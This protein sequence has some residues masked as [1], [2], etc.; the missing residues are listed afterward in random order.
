MDSHPVITK[1]RI[2]TEAGSW[3]FFLGYMFLCSRISKLFFSLFFEAFDRLAHSKISAILDRGKSR[4][5]KLQPGQHPW[6]SGNGG[7]ACLPLQDW[8]LKCNPSNCPYWSSELHVSFSSGL[9]QQPL[10]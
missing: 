1:L 10:G 5:F 6:Y 7:I 3:L 2:V 4:F 9:F 8:P